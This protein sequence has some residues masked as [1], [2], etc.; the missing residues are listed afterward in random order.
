V[1]NTLNK[2]RET[3]NIHE[4][5][6]D[7]V[8]LSKRGVNYLGCCPFHN[9]KTPSL[10]VSPSKGIYKCFGCGTGGDAIKFIR[11]HEH[12]TFNEA[13]EYLGKKYSIAVEWNETEESKQQ[14]TEAQSLRVV[15]EAVTKFLVSSLDEKA[16]NYLI[17]D[18]GFTPATIQEW[19]IGYNP[20]TWQAVTDYVN[21]Q[22]LKADYAKQIGYLS[23]KNNRLFDKLKGRIIFPQHDLAGNVIGFNARVLGKADEGTAKYMN[24]NQCA[25]FDKSRVLFGLFQAKRTILQ[26]DNC[27]LVEGSTDVIS[28]HQSGIK[29]VVAS[30]GTA[31]TIEQL[32]L[33]QKFTSHL[34]IMTD[35]DAAGLKATHKDIGLALS[36]GFRV[37]IIPLPDKADPDSIAKTLSSDEIRAQYINKAVDFIEWKASEL[38]HDELSG[39]IDR[40][41]VVTQLTEYIS[42]VP[43]PIVRNEYIRSVAF[44]LNVDS[45]LL[46]PEIDKLRKKLN[47]ENDNIDEYKHAF[48][49]W[50]EANEQ[51][52]KTGIV[53]IYEDRE[54]TLKHFMDGRENSICIH[55]LPKEKELDSLAAICNKVHLYDYPDTLINLEY[56]KHEIFFETLKLIFI[57]QIDIIIVQEDKEDF[58]EKTGDVFHKIGGV[59]FF[60]YYVTL[61]ILNIQPGNTKHLDIAIEKTASITAHL[62]PNVRDVKIEWVK[63]TF[64]SNGH[65][66]PVTGFKQRVN[67]YLK[68]IEKKTGKRFGI[69]NENVFGLTEKQTDDLNKYKLYFKDNRMFFDSP[70]GVKP[71][72]NFVIIPVLHTI[73]S[74]ESKKVFKLINI[75]RQESLVTMTTQE[76]NKLNKFLCAVEEFG[77]FFFDGENRQLK[78]LKRYLY[79]LTTYSYE[80]ETFGWQRDGFWA[81]S[82]GIDKIEGKQ[83]VEE[84]LPG[85]PIGSLGGSTGKPLDKKQIEN[86]LAWIGKSYPADIKPPEGL[87]IEVLTNEFEVVVT[88]AY[89]TNP[90]N[91]IKFEK[92]QPNSIIA[93]R[94]VT[95]GK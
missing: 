56:G 14:K 45:D 75:E 80:V 35:G 83:K 74:H 40:A 89:R 61:L 58:D 30:N 88:R 92:V 90:E 37:S 87:D 66:L 73:S 76:M 86:I 91:K 77:N 68:S 51:I 48:W 60:D 79:D 55:R 19:Q 84:S 18:R 44:K 70:G 10:T 47:T 52:E 38:K 6:S 43:E 25:I 72:S 71:Y 32:K 67:E 54:I 15:A 1:Q 33:I 69:G 31:L 53:N 17:N 28:L 50:H 4:V 7:F 22:G 64:K 39:A 95:H 63:D 24:A 27:I 23:E 29:N 13:V 34:T 49:P 2:I 65:K 12:Y 41:Q 3:A 59:S 93:W 46:N 9:E 26:A 78:A 20:D 94:H 8:R 62:S 5:I 42:L 85:Y 21:K 81:W 36:L 57:K 16:K 11:E 82:S